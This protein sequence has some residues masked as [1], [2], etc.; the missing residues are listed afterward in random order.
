MLEFLTWKSTEGAE[1]EITFCS[2]FHEGRSLR[3]PCNSQGV[4]DLDALS[5]AAKKNYLF[6]R[7]LIGKEF[8]SPKVM[9]K[10]S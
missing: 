2:L 4:V 8:A 6:A 7:T 5:E 9:S 3:F 10:E 1:F